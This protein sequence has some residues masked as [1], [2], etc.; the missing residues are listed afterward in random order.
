MNILGLV[1]IV[2]GA[3]MSLVGGI[4]FLVVAF[5][6]SVLWG[7]ACLLFPIVSLIFL[8]SHSD[9]ALNPFLTSLGGTLLIYIGSAKI[10][11]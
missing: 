11:I 3:I 5:Q 2:V 4:W 7:L 6:E 1:L 9:R 8:I 10:G